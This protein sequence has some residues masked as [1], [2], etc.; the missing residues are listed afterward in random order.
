MWEIIEPHCADN[1]VRKPDSVAS[2]IGANITSWSADIA[3]RECLALHEWA[4]EGNPQAH[5]IK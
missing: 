4:P 5:L 2:V 1:G 3:M